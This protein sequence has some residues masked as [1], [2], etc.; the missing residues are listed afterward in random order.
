M[1]GATNLPLGAF[2]PRDAPLAGAVGVA[3]AA[4][5]AM[6]ATRMPLRVQPGAETVR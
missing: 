6:I 1:G 2:S 3:E 5:I 4:G